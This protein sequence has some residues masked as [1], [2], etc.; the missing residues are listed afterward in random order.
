MPYIQHPSQ[1]QEKEEHNIGQ[2]IPWSCLSEKDQAKRVM[3]TLLDA[4]VPREDCRM[5]MKAS[6][7]SFLYYFFGGGKLWLY[8]I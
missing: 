8:S 3:G 5:E 1:S 2:R 7:V 6:E 4:K